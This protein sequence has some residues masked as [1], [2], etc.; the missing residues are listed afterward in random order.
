MGFGDR[1]RGEDDLGGVPG[2]FQK[3]VDAVSLCEV[4]FEMIEEVS[5]FLGGRGWSFGS[6]GYGSDGERGRRGKFSFS[7]IDR[8]L[9]INLSKIVV[10]VT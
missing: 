4:S 8:R 6:H 9:E 7:Q 3:L 1:G 5:L 2:D 10:S